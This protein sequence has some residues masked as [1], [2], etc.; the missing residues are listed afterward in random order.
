MST[1]AIITGASTGIGYELALILAK[2]KVNLVLVARSKEKLVALQ[3]KLSSEFGVQVWVISLDLSNASAAQ[4]VF[5]QCQ[6]LGL[7]IN[8]LINNAG[9]GDYGFFHESDW[10]KQAEM[11]QLNIVTLTHLTHLFL[12]NMLK[13]KNGKILNVASIAAFLPGPLMSVY[14]ATKAYVLHF[15]EA[16]ANELE[17]KGITVTTLCPGPTESGFQ[18][19]AAMEDSKL[20]NGKKMASSKEV[21]EYGYRAMMEGKKVA[22]QGTINYLF[23]NSVRF[24]PRNTVLKMVRNVQDKK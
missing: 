17:D 18:K 12:P 3:S 8:Y 11:M 9:F 15:S 2:Q 10:K 22:I 14:Y 24:S 7:H 19:L 20:V 5:D 6:Q 4:Q 21:A 16:I 1:T 13:S 23:V